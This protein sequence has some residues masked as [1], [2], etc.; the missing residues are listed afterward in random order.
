MH[1][2]VLNDGRLELAADL[3][4]EEGQ[5][6]HRHEAAVRLLASSL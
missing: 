5:H 1:D 6:G 4:Q 2:G 3:G